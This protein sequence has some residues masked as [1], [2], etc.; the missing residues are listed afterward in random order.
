MRRSTSTLKTETVRSLRYQVAAPNDPYRVDPALAVAVVAA[1]SED[2]L[3]VSANLY[4]TTRRD[5][6]HRRA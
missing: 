2:A 3:V 5:R 4:P 1:A 6:L